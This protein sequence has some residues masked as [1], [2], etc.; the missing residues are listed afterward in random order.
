MLSCPQRGGAGPN[1][2]ALWEE[3]L[4]Q[5]RGPFLFRRNGVTSLSGPRQIWNWIYR[6]PE[7]LG[8]ICR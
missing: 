7:R 4:G 5:C 6:R 8:I 3:Y 2:L 1:S